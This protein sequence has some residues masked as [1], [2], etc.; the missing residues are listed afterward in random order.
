MNHFR[1]EFQIHPVIRCRGVISG[2][3]EFDTTT[4]IHSTTVDHQSR[5]KMRGRLIMNTRIFDF[6]YA[7]RKCSLEAE[8]ENP[9]ANPHDSS[10]ASSASGRVLPRWEYTSGLRRTLADTMSS[11][12]DGDG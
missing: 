8:D 2:S 10:R 11:H 3:A 7:K 4:S 5:M 12:W 1:G 6:R 9:F